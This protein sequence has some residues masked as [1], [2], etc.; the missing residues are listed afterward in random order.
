MSGGA[1]T[2]DDQAFLN[3]VADRLVL[4]PFAHDEILAVLRRFARR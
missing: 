1:I 3:S 2:A 4:K